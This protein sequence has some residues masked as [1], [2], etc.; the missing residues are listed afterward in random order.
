MLTASLGV[1]MLA[2]WGSREPD[3][4]RL[5]GGDRGGLRAGAGMLGGARDSSR[6]GGGGDHVVVNVVQRCAH[7]H[8][9][10]L[11]HDAPPRADDGGGGAPA[12]GA[13]GRRPRRA[14]ARDR[15][16]HAAA[17]RIGAALT[18]PSERKE[19]V[20]KGFGG[21]LACRVHTFGGRNVMN[22]LKLVGGGLIALAA[23]SVAVAPVTPAQ[24]CQD[25]IA[26]AAQKYFDAR[27]QG[28][29]QVP[30]RASRDRDT[31]PT[32]RPIPT[33]TG[34]IATA[35]TEADDED[36]R[37]SAPAPGGPD[38]SRPRLQGRARR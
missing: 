38:R 12:A 32:A 33:V 11:Q 22:T 21:G 1:R 19:N 28:P 17:V 18:G 37:R 34:A 4:A 35:E 2:G 10:D 27:V 20:D 16:P 13:A 36:H 3:G 9:D 8:G 24:K 23:S 26:V 6:P 30:R 29:G 7:H 31:R 15:G 25:A 5:A 14:V